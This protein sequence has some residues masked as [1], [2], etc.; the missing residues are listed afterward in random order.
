M[1]YKGH[2]IYY[3]ERIK[4]SKLVKYHKWFLRRQYMRAD[5]KQKRKCGDT[6]VETI[7]EKV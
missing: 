7:M 5:T 3:Y 6:H 4:K 1:S 2:K